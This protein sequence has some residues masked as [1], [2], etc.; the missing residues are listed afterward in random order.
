VRGEWL[1]WKKKGGKP[2]FEKHNYFILRKKK[3]GKA[4]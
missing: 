2:P 3:G 1:G 4:D